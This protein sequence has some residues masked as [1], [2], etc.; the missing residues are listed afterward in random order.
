MLLGGIMYAEPSAYEYRD[1]RHKLREP[2]ETLA[3]NYPSGIRFSLYCSERY[4]KP[5]GNHLQEVLME[6]HNKKDIPSRILHLIEDTYAKSI[7]F[8]GERLKYSKSVTKLVKGTKNMADSIA[9]EDVGDYFL[10][11][12]SMSIDSDSSDYQEKN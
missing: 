5:L 9:N 7:A 1:F 4:L 11:L 3:R 10:S 8:E 2:I 12:L 6:F